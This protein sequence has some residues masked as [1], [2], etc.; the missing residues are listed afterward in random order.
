LEQL[1]VVLYVWFKIKHS[2]GV[3][4]SRL[5]LIEKAKEL[6]TEMELTEECAF[7]IGWL[8]RFKTRYRTRKRDISGENKSSDQEAAHRHSCENSA[9]AQF[10]T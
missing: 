5:M 9:T 1:D 7:A 8:A 6:Y 4:V 3:P 10:N 2:E